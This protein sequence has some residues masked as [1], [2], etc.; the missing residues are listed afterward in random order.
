MLLLQQYIKTRIEQLG[1]DHHVHFKHMVLQANEQIVL[2]AGTDI[3]I[4]TD[5]V[6]DIRVESE[7]G[8]FDW[9]S[10]SSNEQIYEHGGDI[11]IENLNSHN[12]H[13]PLIQFTRKH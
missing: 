1:N 3:Y 7:N 9:E 2:K 13:L 6:D 8:L 12:N 11:I 4:I 5:I 10:N